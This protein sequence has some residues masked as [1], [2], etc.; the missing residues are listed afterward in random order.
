MKYNYIR[1]WFEFYNQHLA[2]M[3][4]PVAQLDDVNWATSCC[5]N[6]RRC[7]LLRSMGT[8]FEVNPH[9]G[10]TTKIKADIPMLQ[11]VVRLHL[12]QV[13]SINSHL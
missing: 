13:G 10:D 7:F 3:Q 9:S 8:S 6:Q 11:L 2:I 12:L 1:Q 4:Q 5:P